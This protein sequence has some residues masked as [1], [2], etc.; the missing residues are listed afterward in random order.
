M[1][2][3]AERREDGRQDRHTAGE[4]RRT[5]GTQAG[6]FQTRSRA[7]ADQL[8]LEFGPNLRARCPARRPG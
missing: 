7:G 2:R 4:H 3:N 5:I 1:A 8:G 6:E